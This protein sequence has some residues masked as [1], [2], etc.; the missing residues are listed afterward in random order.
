MRVCACG[1][2]RKILPMQGLERNIYI[3]IKKKEGKK[4]E[5]GKIGRR[6]ERKKKKKMSG[7]EKSGRNEYIAE[8]RFFEKL[9]L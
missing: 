8:R 2:E 5:E 9:N 4:K 6:K 1:R 7:G 3:Y